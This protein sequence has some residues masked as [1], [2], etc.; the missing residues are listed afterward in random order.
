M[1]F[2]NLAIAMATSESPAE[3]GYNQKKMKHNTQQLPMQ[4][5]AS[6]KLILY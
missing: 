1:T 5:D 6:N 4:S 3:D 2:I